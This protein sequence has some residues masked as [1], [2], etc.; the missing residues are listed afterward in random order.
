MP[1]SLRHRPLSVRK[2]VAMAAI[3]ACSEPSVA[4]E[5]H[6]QLSSIRSACTPNGP[7]VPVECSNSSRTRL[8]SAV[9][10]HWRSVGSRCSHLYSQETLTPTIAQVTTYGT[11]VE[12]P[13]VGDEAR[14]AHL[15]ASF[16]HRT[17]DRLRTSRSIRSSQPP[18]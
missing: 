6:S 18:A 8:S 7:Y 2:L 12:G 3:T 1:I 16:T 10:R 5:S 9:R 4:C 11:P 13:L 17:T 14:H 15:V